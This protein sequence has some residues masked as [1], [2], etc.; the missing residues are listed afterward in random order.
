MRYVDDEPVAFIRTWLPADLADALPAD[1]LRDASLHE[2][3]TERA[4]VRIASGTREVRATAARPP[5]D[6]HLGVDPGF[7]LLLLEGESFDQH[8]RVVEVFS[9][10]HRSDR[11]AFDVSLA[12][13]EAIR[14]GEETPEDRVGR[15]RAL[16]AE[17][18]RELDALD[19]GDRV[20]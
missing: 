7:P 1:C 12:P 14:A 9:T 18:Q 19:E 4:G 11:V 10:W 6:A 13:T 17:A 2:L 15:L 20:Q 16:L 8:G 5:I 3:M